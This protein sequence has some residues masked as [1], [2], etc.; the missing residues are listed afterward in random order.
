MALGMIRAN[1]KRLIVAGDCLVKPRKISERIAAA[2][3]Y[4]GVSGL[5]RESAVITRDCVLELP[6]LDKCGRAIQLSFNTIDLRGHFSAGAEGL[7]MVALDRQ[8]FVEARERFLE[9]L[10]GRKGAPPTVQRVDVIWSE[11]VR[12]AEV[13]ERVFV[14]RSIRQ[15][16]S[17]K[18]GPLKLRLGM[19]RIDCKHV[20]ITRDRFLEAL[21]SAQRVAASK[22][23]LDAAGLNGKDLPPTFNCFLE[24][25][26]FGRRG[27]MAR[28]RIDGLRFISSN[29]SG[30][31]HLS[32]TDAMPRPSLVRL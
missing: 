19:R 31:G 28:E 15:Y 29:D 5:A 13:S 32:V 22:Q 14:L 18:V 6:A 11:I 30:M 21:D 8:D 7:G 10:E 23:R 25:A 24:M 9:T 4:L 17:A 20:I 16:N 12:S 1:R 26:P 3:Q 27:S 2:P